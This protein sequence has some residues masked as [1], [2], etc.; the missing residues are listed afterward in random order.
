MLQEIIAQAKLQYPA[1]WGTWIND[2]LFVW[3][4]LA[5]DEYA[6]VMDL[7][8]SEDEFHELLCQA[9]V[10]YP[11]IND[12]QEAPAGFVANL[13]PYIIEE[14]GFGSEDKNRRALNYYRESLNNFV[15]QA[16][17]LIMLAFPALTLKQIKSFTA[18]E[19]WD[20]VARAEWVLEKQGVKITIDFE[21]KQEQP[22][23]NMAMEMYK[24]GIDPM[25]TID[26]KKLRYDSKFIEF[27]FIIGSKWDNQE[28]WNAYSR[29]L[30]AT[31]ES[32]NGSSEAFEESW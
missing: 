16:E 12:Y 19:L 15:V 32:T 17:T 26:P 2:I 18:D 9:A 22:K 20:Y 1:V 14:S 13:A 3:R 25:T 10:I 8:N 28:V 23:K 5:Q 11:K 21:E 6:Y 4:P 27:P 29:D 24:Q 31:H 7:A 30:S